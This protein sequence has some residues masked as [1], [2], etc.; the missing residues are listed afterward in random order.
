M[1]INTIVHPG[2][3]REP[4]SRKRNEKSQSASLPQRNAPLNGWKAETGPFPDSRFFAG[5]VNR[6]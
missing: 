1:W 6:K 4:V 2:G 3:R 5:H